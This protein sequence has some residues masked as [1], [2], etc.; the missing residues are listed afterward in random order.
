M[1]AAKLQKGSTLHALGLHKAGGADW[2]DIRLGAPLSKG[3]AARLWHVEKPGLATPLVAKV[4]NKRGLDQVFSTP[5]EATRVLRLVENRNQ[6]YNHIPNVIWP[7]RLLFTQPT[8]ENVRNHFRGFTMSRLDHMRKL[9]QILALSQQGQAPLTFEQSKRMVLMLCQSLQ[10]LH[11]HPWQFRFGDFSPNNIMFSEDLTTLAFVDADGYQ[12]LYPHRESGTNISFNA[13]GFTLGYSSPTTIKAELRRKQDDPP[14][15]VDEQHDHFV[16]AIHIY[17]IYMAHLGLGGA[18]PFQKFERGNEN[19]AIAAG[20]FTHD[21]ALEHQPNAFIQ[22]QY[23]RIP[24]PIRDAFS[25]TFARG[26]PLTTR[27]WASL[28][29]THWRS[30]QP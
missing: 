25:R 28:C 11:D 19:D 13:A 24:E 21:M 7:R 3:G 14:V 10:K 23:L 16:L 27:E 5:V 26:K 20:R 30:L 2:Y 6:L 15:R 22:Q 1:S 12:F 9:H 4:W 17:Q 29:S 8:R 18:A